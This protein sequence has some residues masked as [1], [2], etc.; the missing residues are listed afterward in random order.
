MKAI[1]LAAGMGV[2]LRHLTENKPKGMLE[3][4]GKSLIEHLLVTLRRCGIDDIVIVR[5]Y[6]AEK[7]DFPGVKYY[8]NK[9][10]DK[11]NMVETL[12]CTEGELTD[13]VIVTYADIIYEVGV[14]KEIMESNHE[15]SV[16]VDDNW[17]EYFKA[18]LGGNPLADAESLV[19]DERGLIKEIGGQNPEIDDVQGQ[20]IGLMKF[21]GQGIQILKDVYHKARDEYWD[22]PWRSGK[23]FQNAYMTDLLQ[24]IIDSGAKVHPVR[25]KNGWLEFDTVEDYENILKWQK[26]N[27]LKR[28]LIYEW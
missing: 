17:K 21:K 18:R 16:I 5:G 22:K 11:T 25:I 9:Y 23:K 2:R 28:F 15:I 20:Y 8:L 12:F 13:E 3:F 7:I 24:E 4:N 1:I 19:Y 10:Y 6:M 27:T 14:L 26:D